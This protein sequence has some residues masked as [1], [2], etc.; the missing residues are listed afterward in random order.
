VV[1][2]EEQAL[3]PDL[4]PVAAP[5]RERV[6]APVLPAVERAAPVADAARVAASA[7]VRRR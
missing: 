2:R 7:A 4:V 5:Q 3:V 1:V 6:L